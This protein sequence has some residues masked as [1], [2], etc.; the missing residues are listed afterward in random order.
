MKAFILSD[1]H[2]Q[3]YNIEKF[4]IADMV[5]HSG[6]FTAHDI[7][8]EP[9]FYEFIDWYAS[10]PYTY[11]VLVAGNHDGFIQLENKKAREY[12]LLHDIIYLEDE[13]ITI[14]GI[15]IY[16]SPWT[17]TFRNWY[18]MDHDYNLEV[19]YKKIPHDINVL[20]TH[21]PA[22]GILDKNSFGQ[23]CGSKSLGKRILELK[24]LRFHICGHIH[25]GYGSKDT[26]D[27]LYVNA[28]SPDKE[29]NVVIDIF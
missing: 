17:P 1:T 3:H 10:L 28:A 22:Y 29:R 16:G 18:F 13:S 26:G 5:I 2:G 27:L 6:D 25:E 24:D 20:I 14:E 4:P 7:F 12:M 11:K 21:G 23:S 8:K 19:L 9:A 15:K